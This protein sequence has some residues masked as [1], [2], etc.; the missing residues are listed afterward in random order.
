[1]NRNHSRWQSGGCVDLA[2][3]PG[4][5]EVTGCCGDQIMDGLTHGAVALF[6]ALHETAYLLN[7][8]HGC[9]DLVKIL[10]GFIN[11]EQDQLVGSAPAEGDL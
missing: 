3:L 1:M 11:C 2:A 4:G 8:E 9:A 7:P 10:A 5:F 6:V